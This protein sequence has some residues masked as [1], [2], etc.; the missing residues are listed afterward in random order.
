VCFFSES[1]PVEVW[2]SKDPQRL[3]SEAQL[4]LKEAADNT[5]LVRAQRDK[6]AEEKNDLERQIQEL[7]TVSDNAALE[8]TELRNHVEHL[9]KEKIRLSGQKTKLQA[10]VD[11]V[12]RELDALRDAKADAEKQIDPVDQEVTKL[13]ADLRNLIGTHATLLDERKLQQTYVAEAA[14][15]LGDQFNM[16]QQSLNC[17]GAMILGQPTAVLE[18]IQLAI[19]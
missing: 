14:A 13:K 9:G 6:L 11:E 8:H 4:K 12:V 16:T 2:T 18:Q 19:G 7:N 17:L 1:F 15:L 10:Q 5:Q 3:L